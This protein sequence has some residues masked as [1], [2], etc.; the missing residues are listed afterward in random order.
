MVESN[1]TSSIAVFRC[2]G[3][4]DQNFTREMATYL[5]VAFDIA[6]S[7]R[8]REPFPSGLMKLYQERPDVANDQSG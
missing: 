4:I 1:V 5:P 6:R 3:A 7:T 2:D 8:P